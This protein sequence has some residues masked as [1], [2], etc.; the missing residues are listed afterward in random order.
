MK[1]RMLEQK[2]IGVGIVI[3]SLLSTF[4]GDA[5][6][7]VFGVLLGLLSIFTKDDILS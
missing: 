1:R 6:F 7:A 3:I 5:T 2:L 4:D